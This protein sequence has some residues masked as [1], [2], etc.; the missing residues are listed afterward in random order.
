[1]GF[2][3]SLPLQCTIIITWCR[4]LAFL[5]HHL[6]QPSVIFE[7]I[8]GILLGPSGLMRGTQEDLQAYHY[9]VFTKQSLTYLQ[10]V[11]NI[12][13]VL[14]LFLVG[15]ELDP[16]LLL[17]HARRAG[18]IAIVGMGVPFALGVGISRVLFD[19]LQANDPKYKD[20]NFTGFYVFIGTSFSVF[21][22]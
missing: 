10:L 4:G 11:A 3:H 8:G 15:M 6:K 16:K 7:I 20:A 17:T 19:T 21:L 14:Y 1:M 18:G 22:V 9:K 2:L 12:G 13:L 5:G